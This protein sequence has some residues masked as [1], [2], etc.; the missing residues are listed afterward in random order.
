MSILLRIG[1]C[2]MRC[3][4]AFPAADSTASD[5]LRSISR[6]GHVADDHLVH[7]RKLFP[8]FHWRHDLFQVQPHQ[9]IVV[10]IAK[11]P[12]ENIDTAGMRGV[13]VDTDPQT[14]RV[15]FG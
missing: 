8:F 3:M 14:N 1:G 9:D 4:T 11:A 6:L 7:R 5:D 2:L 12:A 10:M 13:V 15:M